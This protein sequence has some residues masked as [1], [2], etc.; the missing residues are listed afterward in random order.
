MDFTIGQAFIDTYPPEA[1]MWCDENNAYIEATGNNSFIIKEVPVHIPTQ[2][3]IYQDFVS[4]IQKRLDDFAKTRS[5]DGI[6][7]LCS[8]A[9]SKDAKFSAEGQLGVNLRDATWAKGYE[10]LDEVKAGTRPIPTWEE[11]EALL[12]VLAWADG[13]DNLEDKV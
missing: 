2:E 4:K 10:L 11:L 5:Y 12:P 8:Y 13:I 1:A 6:L 3:E 9:T 7:S